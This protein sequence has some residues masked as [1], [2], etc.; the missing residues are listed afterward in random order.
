M[1]YLLYHV[2]SQYCICY[3]AVSIKSRITMLYLLQCYI[4]EITHHNA[5][6]VTMLYL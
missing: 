5:V 3:N 4:C 6:S 1:L 2:A